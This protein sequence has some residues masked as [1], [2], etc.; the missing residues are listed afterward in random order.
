MH[1]VRCIS[2]TTFYIPLLKPL[3]NNCCNANIA[4]IEPIYSY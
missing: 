3:Y 2:R 1:S 4:F